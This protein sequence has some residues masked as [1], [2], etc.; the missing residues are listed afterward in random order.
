MP[1]TEYPI[2]LNF[3]T[4]GMKGQSLC[5]LFVIKY[6]LNLAFRPRKQVSDLLRNGEQ[7]F[8]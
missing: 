7:T 2:L 8:L 6:D 3:G 5:F 1:N 4:V